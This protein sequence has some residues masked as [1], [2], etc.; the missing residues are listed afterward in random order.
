[1]IDSLSNLPTGVNELYPNWQAAFAE[2]TVRPREDAGRKP[3]MPL[4]SRGHCF[5]DDRGDVW[6]VLRATVVTEADEFSGDE[7]PYR[8]AYVYE[9]VNGRRQLD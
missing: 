9:V 7:L 1:M 4:L 2:I 3:E 8:Y 5:A 6:T